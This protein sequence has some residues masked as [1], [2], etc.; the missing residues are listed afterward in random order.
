MKKQLNFG[1]IGAAGIANAFAQGV[2]DAKGGK[3]YAVAARNKERAEAF[4]ENWKM[5]KA[6]GSY[7]ELVNDPLVDV[8]Y[9][10]TPNG[11]HKEHSILAMKHKKHVMCEKPFASNAREVEE[12]IAVAKEEDVF[13]ME[14]M[15]TRYFPLVQQVKKW[16]EENKIGK[17]KMIEAD[18]GF[19]GLDKD[20]IRYD[21]SLAGGALMDVG[22]YPISFVSYI[23]G[24]Q[25]QVIKALGELSE[26]GVDEQNS[27]I[28]KYTDGQAA[29]I[30]SAM[31]V[32]TARNMYILG[33]KGYIH[34]PNV[35]QPKSCEIHIEGQEVEKYEIGY[36]GNGY[37]YEVQEVIDCILAGKK[38][39][40]SMPV[41]ESLEIMNTMDCVRAEIGVVFPADK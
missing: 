8:I 26:S 37:N 41:Q 3:L 6:Y 20:N 11:L 2:L 28:F 32:T 5:E 33:E 36:E 4:A 34:I 18:F 29:V 39:S 31:N 22:I 21:L 19:N 13:L 38:E 14:G 35:W 15:W 30:S 16:V 40:E 17:V 12:M 7:E 25:P 1:I 23:Y 24:K 10:A 9:V 27:M